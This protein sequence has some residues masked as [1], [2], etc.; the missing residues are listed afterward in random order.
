MTGRKA[1]QARRLAEYEEIEKLA[2]VVEGKS[3]KLNEK[4]CF[5]NDPLIDPTE[6]TDAF[7]AE[8]NALV[9]VR[10]L[11]YYA[12]YNYAAV[13]GSKTNFGIFRKI[14]WILD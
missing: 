2:S 6:E 10:N 14:N 5:N 3:R 8:M 9:R 13:R 12:P 4:L 1:K 11:R 7:I